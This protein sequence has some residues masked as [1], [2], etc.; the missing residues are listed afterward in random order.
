MKRVFGFL[1][2]CGVFFVGAPAFPNTKAGVF[3][4]VGGKVL[5][6]HAGAKPISA[7]PKGE[8]FL[9]D[10]IE[11]KKDSAV[12]LKFD[13]GTK[14]VL[15]ENAKIAVTQFLFQPKQQKRETV[16]QIFFGKVKAVV[17][18]TFD[19]KTSKTQLQTPTATVG[20]RGTIV[21]LEV[22]QSVTK[23]YCL[24]GLLEAFSPGFPDKIVAISEGKF[25]EVLKGKF[26]R[27]PVD[28]PAEVL[29]TIESQFGFPLSLKGAVQELKS[30]L[31]IPF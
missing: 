18:K 21:A 17:T 29:D 16:I 4:Q 27:V 1:F 6:T 9:K 13:D 30:R 20:I 22:T 11:T 28:I 12:E 3:L 10:V 23:V 5:V 25:S 2:F 24:K 14:M 26:P 15:R 19:K 8:I 31:P 7:V